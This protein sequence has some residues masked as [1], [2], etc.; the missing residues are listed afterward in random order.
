MGDNLVVLGRVALVVVT[1]WVLQS[2]VFA[3]HVVASVQVGVLVAAAVAA[4][5][6]GGPQRGVATGFALGV[7]LDLLLITPFG[8]GALTC[9]LAG[10]GAGVAGGMRLRRSRIYPLAIGLL[11]GAAA[12]LVFAVAGELVG[13]PYLSNPDL[14]RTVLVQAGATAVLVLPL[15]AVW[16]WAFRPPAERR[17]VVA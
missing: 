8:L 3:L 11:G 1:L 15:G 6:V 5:A 13:R 7:A 4:G 10:Y 16:R 14:L 9:T 12:V 17:M 2:S